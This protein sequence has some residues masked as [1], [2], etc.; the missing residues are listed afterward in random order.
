MR[1]WTDWHRFTT[2]AMIALAFLMA[3]AAAEPAPPADPWHHARHRE[4]T[5]LTAAEIRRLFNGLVITPLRAQLTA[6]CALSAKSS[7]GPPGA[8]S[9]KAGSAA[10]TTSTDS[11]SSSAH[12]EAT[13]P[14]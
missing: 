11:P 3:Y 2:L 7:A 9:T 6:R 5:A 8:A 1:T 14:Y 13:L 10:A 4:P 12:N